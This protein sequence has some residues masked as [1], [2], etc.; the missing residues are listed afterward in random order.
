VTLRRRLPHLGI[1]LACV[2]T[3]AL[4]GCGGEPLPVD[5]GSVVALDRSALPDDTEVVSLAAPTSASA[6]EVVAALDEQDV[7]AE[8]HGRTD[9]T[10]LS[11]DPA[12]VAGLVGT[13]SPAA[14]GRSKPFVVLVFDEPASALVFAAAADVVL[15]FPGASTPDSAVDSFFSGNLVG[16]YAPE[17]TSVGRDSFLGALTSLADS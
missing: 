15:D 3:L 12:A 9:A 2:A 4:G 13:V 8:A 14:K 10:G 11:I 16:Y 1:V 7:R 5:D 6:A 17:Q